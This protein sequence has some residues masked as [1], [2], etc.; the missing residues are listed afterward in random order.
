MH[1]YELI[2]RKR[3]GGTLEAA[4]I[5]EFIAGYTAGSVADYQMAAMCMAIFF[6][7]L[8]DAELAAWAGAM[9]RSGEVIDLSEIPAAKVDK[10]STGGVGDKVSLALAPLAAD[11]K[12][13]RKNKGKGNAKIEAKK[14]MDKGA[15]AH[16]DGN[17]DVALTELQAAYALDPQPKLLFAIAQVQVKLDNCPDAIANYEK[18]LATEKSKQ[19]QAVVKQAIEACNQKVAAA[20]PATLPP[21]T[22]PYRAANSTATIAATRPSETPPTVRPASESSRMPPENAPQAIS[23]V[24]HSPGVRPDCTAAAVRRKK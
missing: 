12:P 6:K 17:F 13:F 15:K 9:L 20:T 19:K 3:D 22:P 21:P 8:N 14:H 2:K 7:G 11:A 1:A 4:E 10:H 5:A 24:L 23:C 18:F 16:K